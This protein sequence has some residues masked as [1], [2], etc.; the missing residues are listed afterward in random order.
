MSSRGNVLVGKCPVRKASVGEVSSRGIRRSGS[1]RRGSV[2]RGSVLGEVSVGVLSSRETVLQSTFS[3][4]STFLKS[5][6]PALF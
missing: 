1:V 4:Y 3:P 5:I 6:I 2:C